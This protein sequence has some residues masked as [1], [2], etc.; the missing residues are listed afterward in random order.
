MESKTLREVLQGLN[1][2]SCCTCQYD[3]K[4]CDKEY[5]SALLCKAEV[6]AVESALLEWAGDGVLSDKEIDDELEQWFKGG[7]YGISR[8]K[9]ISLFGQ[10]ALKLWAEAW[11]LEENQAGRLPE[12][13]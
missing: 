3:I 7:G 10:I 1:H 2:A 12:V 11:Y 4:E 6:K 5:Y 8:E 9:C 13:K